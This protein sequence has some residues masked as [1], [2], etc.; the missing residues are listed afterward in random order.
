MY[1]T[2]Q[3]NFKHTKEFLDSAILNINRGEVYAVQGNHD[4][5]EMLPP[6][7]TMGIRLLMDESVLLVT[8]L[9]DVEQFVSGGKRASPLPSRGPQ[10]PGRFQLR[11]PFDGKVLPGSPGVSSRKHSPRPSLSSGRNYP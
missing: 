2:W 9:H 7:E 5:I 10:S 8:G 3:G 1:T 6:L 11:G 4:F